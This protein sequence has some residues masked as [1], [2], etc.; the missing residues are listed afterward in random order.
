[1]ELTDGIDDALLDDE[2][3]EDDEADD[4]LYGDGPSNIPAT[5]GAAA[6]DSTSMKAGDYIF[7]VHDSLVN[8]APIVDTTFGKSASPTTD[9]E[10]LNYE[11]VTSDLDLI[12][13][14][15]KEEAGALAI[16]H[17]NIQPKIIGRFE[18]PEARGI[19]T[20]SA[21]RPTP[22]GLEANKEKSAMS[23]DYGIDAQYDRLMIVSKSLTDATET[24]DVYALTSAGFEALSGTEFEPAAGSTIEAGT[25]GNGMRIIQVLKSEVRS[26]D[27]GKS[28]L[29]LPMLVYPMAVFKIAKRW[30]NFISRFYWVSNTDYLLFLLSGELYGDTYCPI[31][32]MKAFITVHP[33]H[34]Q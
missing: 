11:G 25:L 33:S 9:D 1:L 13:A 28:H 16:I 3:L 32:S 18:F 5:N 8:I 6:S 21:K 29:F 24:S 23:G 4:D 27:G 15:G 30:R 17:Q 34:M 14:T 12:V 10:R 7:Q 20:I 22:K 26:Y 31:A 2:D 19:W